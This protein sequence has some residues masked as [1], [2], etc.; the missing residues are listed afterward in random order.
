MQEYDIQIVYYLGAQ[1][2]NAHALS[3][4]NWPDADPRAF[5]VAMSQT[6]VEE[7]HLAQQEGHL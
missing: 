6:L 2:T 5:I 4:C 3:W 1:N 7:L